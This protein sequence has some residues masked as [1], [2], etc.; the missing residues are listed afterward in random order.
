MGLNL[1]IENLPRMPDGGPLSYVLTG[2]RG[3]DIGR[4]AH[5]DWTLP[6]PGRHVSG[7]HCEIRFK[8]G[9]YFLYDVSRN[10]TFLNGSEHRLQ[11]PHRLRTG[12][13]L[14]IG[15]YIIEVEVEEEEARPAEVAALPDMGDLWGGAENP[16]PPLDPRD[17]RPAAQMVPVR[18]DFLE[19]AVDV[20]N[21]PGSGFVARPVVPPER[22]AGR[23]PEPLSWDA[24]PM[25]LPPPPEPPSPIPTPRRSLWVGAGPEGPWSSGPEQTPPEPVLPPAPSPAVAMRAPPSPTIPTRESA[26]VVARFAKGAGLPQ[27]AIAKRDAGD[28]AEWLGRLLLLVTDNVKQLLEARGQTKRIVRSS[29]QT[30]IAALDNNPLKF[31][32]SAGDALR[33]MIGPP[34]RSYLDAEQALQQGFD[35]LKSHQ[36]R[37]FAAMQ[38]ALTMLLDDMDPKSIQEAL[39]PDKGV[40]GWVGSRG[41]RLWAL[42]ESRWQAR[43]G[44]NEKGMQDLFM[45]YFAECYDQ[46]QRPPEGPGKSSRNG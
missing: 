29:N 33:V 11:S 2:A 10:G 27:D 19:W 22:E 3:A 42:Y 40:A 41:A 24:G 5:L 20:P 34:T 18:P 14:L 38:K 25:P 12:D 30:M 46:A 28:L 17:L 1:R 37:T 26:D 7:K 15:H 44:R 6:D 8:N 4:D 16:A 23:E 36:V 32:P 9:S 13:R 31:S 35:D 39:G 43:S 21:A 45:Q